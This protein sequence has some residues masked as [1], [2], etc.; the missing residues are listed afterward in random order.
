MRCSHVRRQVTAGRG[1]R[2]GWFAITFLIGFVLYWQRDGLRGLHGPLAAAAGVGLAGWAVVY[3]GMHSF[4]LLLDRIGQGSIARLL[5]GFALGNATAYVIEQRNEL[6]EAQ[7]QALK[8]VSTSPPPLA[9]EQSAAE[10]TQPGAHDGK[11][12]PEEEKRGSSALESAAG[13]GTTALLWLAAVVVFVAIAAPHLDG[14]LRR[15]TSLKLPFGELQIAS[16]SVRPAIRAE[17]IDLF[18]EETSMRVLSTY[19]DRITLDAQYIERVELPD[20][21]ERLA[22]YSSSDIR[23]AIASKERAAKDA[24]NLAPA[25]GEIVSPTA[26]CVSD[27]I[28]RGLAIETV[29][30]K[31]RGAADALERTLV[32]EGDEARNAEYIESHNKFWEELKQLPMAAIPFADREGRERCEK[33]VAS[34]STWNEKYPKIKD[35]KTAPYLYVAAFLFVTFVRDEDVAFRIIDERYRRKDF[36]KD[37]SFLLYSGSFLND[38]GRGV[39]VGLDLLDHMRATARERFETLRRKQE[40]CL[41]HFCLQSTVTDISKFLERERAA[42]L[43]ATNNLAYYVAVDLTQGGRAGERYRGRLAEFADDLDKAIKE[44]Y[45]EDNRYGY[46]DTFAFVTTVLEA[47]KRDPDVER[48]RNMTSMLERVVEVLEDKARTYDRVDA[49]ALKVARAHL[50]SAR[51]LAGR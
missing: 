15:M 5:L 10:A 16:V 9:R 17:A 23:D 34:L 47:Q 43:K 12:G 49:T 51:E 7:V 11:P 19:A 27:A 38:F 42:M 29:K 28:A 25:F 40:A 1:G 14:W 26:R 41:R 50:A 45:D 46:M 6:H 39:D 22:D 13:M 24:K 21:R 8:N 35:Y 44:K 33:V 48:I 3:A 31:A 18:A 30:A 4:D 36:V 2:M 37:Y 32:L 20:L